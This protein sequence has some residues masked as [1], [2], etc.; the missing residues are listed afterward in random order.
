MVAAALGLA[1]GFVAPF[2]VV[3]V[4]VANSGSAPGLLGLW[5]IIPIALAG[6]AIAAV[7]TESVGFVWATV[8]GVWS[9]IILGAWSFG[10]F[11]AWEGLALLVAGIVH[12]VAVGP[13]WRL[14]LVPLWLVL[15]ASG[16]CPVFLAVDIIR[17][18]RSQ[19]N[20]LVTH[21]PVVLF[22]S[23]LC[24]ATLTL[25]GACYLTPMVWRGRGSRNRWITG[26]L[27][28]VIVALVLVASGLA[29]NG[30]RAL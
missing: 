26:A 16:L 20:L 2:R 19:S 22:G 14:L 18:T 1:A 15:G 27:V 21:A 23:W 30:V 8:G 6:I 17:E 28:L 9:F 24:G 4:F 7:R 3:H 12:L 25:L 10:T 5:M 11:F 13:R 29:Q